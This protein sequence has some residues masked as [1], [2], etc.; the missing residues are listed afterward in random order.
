[1][2]KTTQI[3]L[4]LVRETE[5][6]AL[7]QDAEGR[8]GWLRF[9]SV[10]GTMD[11]GFTA[12]AATFEKAVASYVE[13]T[14][15]A[16]ADRDWKS[17]FHEITTIRETEKAVAVQVAF[18]C[19]RIDTTMTRTAWIPKSVLRDGKAPGWILE[20]KAREAKAELTGPVQDMVTTTISGYAV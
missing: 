8:K 4:T 1:M 18:D 3:S 2:A 17:D 20:A 9:A 19:D 16:R 13:R 12:N 14:E 11:T 15:A 10:K 7:M 5:K 6:A